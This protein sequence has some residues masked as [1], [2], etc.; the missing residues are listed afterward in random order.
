MTTRPT[1]PAIPPASSSVTSTVTTP[2][3]LQISPPILLTN[4]KSSDFK[5]F[6][7][8]F[9]NYLLIVSASEAQKLPLLLNSL[10]IDGLN[11]YDGL[12]DPKT[13][14]TNALL[15]LEE[16]FDGKSSILVRRKQFYEAKQLTYESV[17]E[18]A[19]RL[20]RLAKECEFPASSSSD[21]LRDIFVIGVRRN[22]R[23]AEHMA[24][25][26]TLTFDV[27]LRKAEAFE[28]ATLG[29]S[30][31]EVASSVTQ[32]PKVRVTQEPKSPNMDGKKCFRCGSSHHLANSDVCKARRAQCR[33]CQKV[34]HF[35]AQCRAQREIRSSMRPTGSNSTKPSNS[36]TC[37]V[38]QSATP[39]S[40]SAISSNAFAF[41][42]NAMSTDEFK[43]HV[44]INDH[45]VECLIDTGASVNVIPNNVILYE[46]YPP[47]CL[48]RH[49]EIFRSRF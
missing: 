46:L 15:R 12:N 30:E 24:T 8:Q 10:G 20:R 2:S 17:S 34:G 3:T 25:I 19:V 35:Q 41:N 6:K 29:R 27:A 1:S 23:L 21:L 38:S 42:V 13:T 47:L 26:T 40:A 5:Y 39:S 11:I 33:A 18:F 45:C 22:A 31:M 49:G 48:S 44:F 28:R 4:P 32:D 9:E 14:F 7:R 16:Y 43:R 36:A 37:S